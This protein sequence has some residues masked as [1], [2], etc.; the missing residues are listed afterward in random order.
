MKGIIAGFGPDL[1]IEAGYYILKNGGNCVDAIIISL[2]SS[3]YCIGG[4]GIFII[5]GPGVGFKLINFQSI[6]P[7]MGIT[8]KTR[9]II[10]KKNNA[11]YAPS[12]NILSILSIANRWGHVDKIKSIA[13][14]NKFFNIDIINKI[15]SNETVNWFHN[16]F[17][18]NV[19]QH[20][21]TFQGGLVTPRDFHELNFIESNLKKAD[22]NSYHL[23]FPKMELFEPYK[24][25]YAHII[26]M[27]ADENGFL[28]CLTMEFGILPW[29]DVFIEG[30]LKGNWIL[31]SYSKTHPPHKIPL[32]SYPFIWEKTGGAR[33]GIVHLGKFDRNINDK[34]ISNDF[35][36]EKYDPLLYIV[37]ADDFK[38]FS[39]YSTKKELIQPRESINSNML[40]W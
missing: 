10:M 33:K 21:G 11:L 13:K 5:N 23:W 9:D 4:S 12:P 16:D 18:L 30:S 6:F 36:P 37:A 38:Q 7:G 39:A 1:D 40:W 26:I 20:T 25:K 34:I 29:R 32:H 28:A 31:T 3:K 8:K 14:K 22:T 35:E 2:L 24:D 17:A 15:F 19:S 27:A